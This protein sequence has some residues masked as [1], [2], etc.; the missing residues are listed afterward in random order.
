MYALCNYRI[1]NINVGSN[2]L[3]DETSLSAR[4]LV[5]E[6]YMCRHLR[7]RNCK[8]KYQRIFL[9]LQYIRHNSKVG[10]F[11]VYTVS[12]P[13]RNDCLTLYLFSYSGDVNRGPY[14][15][16]L[17][18]TLIQP[19]MKHCTNHIIRREVWLKYNS[20]AG[21]DYADRH[22]ANT[23]TVDSVRTSR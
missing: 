2:L 13:K 7:P 12:V 17:R 1:T 4:K 10:K 23:M 8:R 14:N 20:L 5:G 11:F 16:H 9:L 19:I 15:I 6:G 22:I 18:P 21:P 3:G